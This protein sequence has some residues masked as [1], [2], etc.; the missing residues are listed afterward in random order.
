MNPIAGPPAS[1]L[2]RAMAAAAAEID[3]ALDVLLPPVEGPEARL[4]EAMR[5]AAIGGG[6]RL[7]GFLVLE[8]ARQFG[9]VPPAPR[10]AWPA[11]IEMV[12]AYSLVH[13]D[14][15][16]MDDDDLRRGKPTV[17]RAFDEATAILAGDALQTPRLHRAGRG[18]HAPRPGGAHRAGARACR[19]PP[20]RAACAAGRC[21]TC[22]PK[23][24]SEPLDE[25]E[26]GRLQR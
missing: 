16:A 3:E 26:I 23:R 4:F 12:H 11:A 19:V 17:H 18:G 1:S 14:L 10:S 9:V 6:K 15:P 2:P 25:A 13:D 21:S 24:P 8:G 22:W 5:Y 7:R 20:G